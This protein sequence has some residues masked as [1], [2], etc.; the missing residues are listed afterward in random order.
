MFYLG[1]CT[2]TDTFVNKFSN[3]SALV[4]HA[5][6]LLGS[7]SYNDASKDDFYQ[8]LIALVDGYNIIFDKFTQ[9]VR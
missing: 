5:G 3:H 9:N 4:A 1:V 6:I 7:R 8:E 2:R